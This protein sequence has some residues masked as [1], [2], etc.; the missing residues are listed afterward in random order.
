MLVF[1]LLLKSNGAGS[2][3]IFTKTI[4]GRSSLIS[5]LSFCSPKHGMGLSPPWTQ[6]LDFVKLE[7]FHSTQR[8]LHFQY[9]LI[10]LPHHN[11]Y[12]MSA[13]TCETY[14]RIMSSNSPSLETALCNPVSG[15]TESAIGKWC[16]FKTSIGDLWWLPLVAH[17]PPTL[18]IHALLKLMKQWRLLL[19]TQVRWLD[20]PSHK[21][22]S[23]VF[24]FTTG[25]LWWYWRSWLRLLAST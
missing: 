6:W 7:Y 25:R 20:H 3:T 21:N 14:P 8:L 5:T 19:V 16:T 15:T 22:S 17:A 9:L 23:I 10:T 1:L 4:Q 2:A 13:E 24:K 12:G 11:V 18:P